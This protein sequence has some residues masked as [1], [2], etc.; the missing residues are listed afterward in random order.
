MCITVHAQGITVD[1][2]NQQDCFGETLIMHIL[3]SIISVTKFMCQVEH[4]KEMVNVE[5]LDSLSLVHTFRAD[6]DRLDDDILGAGRDQ[7]TRALLANE[8]PW[9][10]W[11]WT[12]SKIN[13]ISSACILLY[14]RWILDT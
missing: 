7:A 3:H 13:T 4:V 1:A 8:W 9:S 11:M 14:S 2:Q 6:P 12:P 10:S 5:D